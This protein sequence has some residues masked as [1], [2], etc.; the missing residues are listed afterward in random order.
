[1]TEKTVTSFGIFWDQWPKKVAKRDAE[2]AWAKISVKDDLIPIL[3]FIE[4]ANASGIWANLQY[5]PH[6]GSFL[7]GRRWLD[8]LPEALEP[9][10]LRSSHPSGVCADD[11]CRYE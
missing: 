6:P 2:K 5:V 7:R 4:A 8:E 11:G 1:M 9:Q 10:C 3:K